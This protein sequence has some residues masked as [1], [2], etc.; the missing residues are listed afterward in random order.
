VLTD[1]GGVPIVAPTASSD[2]PGSIVSMMAP[3]D[4]GLTPPNYKLTIP[5]SGQQTTIT[6]VQA[7]QDIVSAYVWGEAL[8]GALGG[9]VVT[10]LGKSL[11]PLLGGLATVTQNYRTCLIDATS[12]LGR[13]G[14]LA[15]YDANVLY[16]LGRFGLTLAPNVIQATYNLVMTVIATEQAVGQVSA[17]ING[18]KQFTIP[19]ASGTTPQSGPTSGETG[20]GGGTPAGP[21][22]VAASNSDGQLQVQLANFPLG[23]T[24]YFCH[25]GS[26]YPTGGDITGNSWVDVTSPGEY[27]GT[28]CSG[29]GNFWIGFQATNRQD[30]YSNQVTLGDPAAAATGS[31]SQMTV[32]LSNFPLGTTY[33]FC[34]NGSGYPTG[35]AITSHSSVDVASPNENLGTLC[36]GSGNFWIGFQATDGHDYYSN[37]V[38]LT[39]ATP[40]T[41]VTASG[42][43]MTVQLSNFPLGTTYYFCHN[44]SGYPTGGVIT[45]HSSVDVTSP[46]E[47]LGTLCSGSGN[48]WIGFQ[49]TNGQDYYSNQ[50]TLTGATP[51]AT[52]TASGGELL[53]QL[54]NFPLGTTYYFCHN[55]SGYPTGGAITGN[56]SVDVTSADEDLGALC[57]GSGNF[58]IGFQATDGHDYYSNQVTLG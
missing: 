51:S 41:T 33:Y 26:G 17:W 18:T 53:V 57:S 21:A 12:W 46:D 24:Y 7:P 42:G 13:I 32:Q 48:F 23:K 19:A 9:T 54:A 27:L 22:S 43:E 55:G 5:I 44:G 39:G 14:C 47:Y 38:T 35:G 16:A 25:S 36:S 15:G 49:A 3:M 40:S 10:G 52:V 4:D 2:L 8:Y 1:H 56:S 50:V 45:S 28:L 30:Y 6:I 31:G 58:W 11:V 20:G 34:H 29:S 37:Q